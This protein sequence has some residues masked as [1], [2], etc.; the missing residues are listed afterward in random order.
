MPLGV[1]LQGTY[2]MDFIQLMVPPT[3]L[4]IL[5]TCC[6]SQ[7]VKAPGTPNRN[8]LHPFHSTEQTRK[9]CFFQSLLTQLGGWPRTRDLPASEAQVLGC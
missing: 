8:S 1:L 5:C 2:A 6:A 9:L 3:L 7:A 4:N